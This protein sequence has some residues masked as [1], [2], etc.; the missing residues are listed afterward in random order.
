MQESARWESRLNVGSDV[1]D[2]QHKILFDLIKD[3]SNAIRAG[4]SMRVVDVLLGVLRDLPSSILLPKKNI[5]RH[6]RSMPNTA[7]SIMR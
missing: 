7:C 2:S 4:A 6:M 3:L 1:I 5:L